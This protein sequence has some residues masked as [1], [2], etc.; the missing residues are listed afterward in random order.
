MSSLPGDRLALLAFAL[1]SLAWAEEPRLPRFVNAA[2][3]SGVDFVSA[4]SETTQKY[5][6]TTMLGGVAMLDY[7]SDGRLDLFFVNGARVTDPMPSGARPDKS[8][9]RYWDR[10]YRNQGNGR[11]SDVTAKAGLQG[12]FYAQGAA[13]GDYD[14]DGDSDLYVTGIQGNALYRNEGDG[15]FRE[16][17]RPAGVA[18]RGW[19]TSAAFLD[20]DA[21]GRLDLAVARYVDWTFDKNPYCGERAAARRSYCHPDEFGPLPALLYRNRGDGTFEDVS[22]SAGLAAAPQKGL[23]VAI[24]DYD[25]DGR[26]DLFFA[27]DSWPQ[28]LFRNG[29]K[30]FTEEGLAL[31]VAYDEDGRDFGGMGADFQDYDNDGRPDLFVNALARQGYHLYRN[32]GDAFVEVSIAAGIAEA[33]KL[34]SGWGAAFLDFDNDGWKDLFVAQGHVMDNIEVTQPGLH[35]REPLMMLRNARGTYRD[36]STDLGESFREPLA[37]R[38][39]AAGDLDND[40]ALDLVVYRNGGA[41]LILHNEGAGGAHWLLVALEGV[42]SNRDGIGAALRL[43]ANDGSEQFVTASATGS[44][45]SARDRRAHF[46]LGAS[47]GVKLLEIR[48]PSGRRQ[49]LENIAADQILEVREPTQ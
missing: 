43:V 24:N 39:S 41:P 44:Y 30:G 10:L 15:T 19:S 21:D 35:Y 48:W 27:N 37:S 47:S 8:D 34:T 33:T 9:P 40:G 5:L 6:P 3:G 1:A 31:G 28:H 46:G 38:G 7:D 32:E 49:R 12:S 18:G 25:G 36:V 2:G 23:G 13:V 22:E 20:Y 26:I 17:G 29:P 14:N 11:F 16:V 45:L 42:E 4:P